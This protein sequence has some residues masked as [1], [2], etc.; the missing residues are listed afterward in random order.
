LLAQTLFSADL[1]LSWLR[2]ERLRYRINRAHD[3]LKQFFLQDGNT[4]RPNEIAI[5]LAAFTDYECAKDEAALPFDGA[6]FEKL[7]PV[8]SKQW[9]GMKAQ[10]NIK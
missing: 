1:V 8:L 4:N 2:M 7:N 5:I 10:L 6:I 3:S 9:E